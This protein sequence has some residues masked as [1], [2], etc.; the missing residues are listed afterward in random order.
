MSVKL[1]NRKETHTQLTEYLDGIAVSN[2]L[3]DGIMNIPV[4]EAF[5]PHIKELEKKLVYIAQ[6]HIA[7]SISVGDVRG[8]LELLHAKA[9]SK[10]REF[11]L[12][13]I[14][15]CRKPNSNIQVQQ[16]SM[17]KFQYLYQFLNAHCRQVRLNSTEFRVCFRLLR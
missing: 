7:N 14:Y 17:L 11:M 8:E 12:N 10:I 2:E 16:D 1:K 5:V 6:P 15:A 9:A 4:S 3:I 13:K